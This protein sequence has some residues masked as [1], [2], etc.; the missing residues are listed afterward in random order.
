M[1]RRARLLTTAIACCAALTLGAACGGG[2]DTSAGP[3]ASGPTGAP[4][5]GGTAQVLQIREPSSMDPVTMTNAWQI[6]GFVGNAL[7]GTLMVNDEKTDELSYTMAESFDTTD[8]GATFTLKLRPGLL[9]SDGTPL[10]AEAVKVNW[11][12]HRDPANASPYLSEASLVAAIEVV[13]ATTLTVKMKAPTPSFPRAMLTT[14][15]NWI[16]SPAALAKGKDS[17]DRNPVGAGPYTLKS[18]T[19]QDRIELTRNTRYHDAPRPYLDTITVRTSND[20]SQRYNTLV[21]GGADVVIETNADSLD[22][23]ADAGYTTDV[24][25]LNGGLFLAMNMRKAP[26]DDLR[27]RQ[28]IAAA[29]DMDTLNLAVYNG[30]GKTVDTLFSDSSPLYVDAPLRRTDKATAQRLFDELAAEG[31]PVE[32]TFTAY[33]TSEMKDT[34]ENIQAQL[35]AY[36]NVKVNIRVVDFPE[37]TKLGMAG[38]FDM[39]VWS[40]SFVDPDPRV[41]T[42]FRSDSRGN[43]PGV[44][45]PQLDEALATGRTATDTATRKAAYETFQQRLIALVPGVFTVRANPGL[46]AAEDVGGVTQYGLGSLLPD[47]LWIRK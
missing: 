20:A 8:Q 16:A 22:K 17:F 28:A 35:S 3:T 1:A 21:S 4:V 33:T 29:I 27:A 34:A 24:T 46:M 23:A 6:S 47:R 12:R 43:F 37:A 26:F 5:Q 25:P 32:F 41:W 13:D 2:D 45:D 40:S 14:S 19:R 18:W 15:M 38:D 31:K 30:A 44:D 42:A 39:L 10:D 7:Y 11:D 9:F 36:K